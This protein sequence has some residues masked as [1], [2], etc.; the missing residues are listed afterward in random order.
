MNIRYTWIFTSRT[1]RLPLEKT[2]LITYFSLE[3]A[4][5]LVSQSR[6]LNKR[7]QLS[8]NKST[9]GGKGGG[10]WIL[11]KNKRGGTP[12]RDPIREAY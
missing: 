6:K 5:Q 11:K 8:P 12:F 10:S 1:F 2:F 3:M 9:G 4:Y 7:G